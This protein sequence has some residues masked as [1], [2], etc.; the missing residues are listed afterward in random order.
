[1]AAP[2]LKITSSSPTYDG[3]SP[4]KLFVEIMQA[5]A[6]N[7]TY[8]DKVQASFFVGSE[9]IILEGN[10]TPPSKVL[11]QWE[12]NIFEVY[13]IPAGDQEIWIKTFSKEEGGWTLRDMKMV[14]FQS[15]QVILPGDTVPGQ[16]LYPE[17]TLPALEFLANGGDYAASLALIEQ[18]RL[19]GIESMLTP[20]PSTTMP[21]APVKVAPGD[22]NWNLWALGLALGALILSGKKLKA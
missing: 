19:A 21:K 9:E 11:S 3:V 14:K 22:K 10:V 15:G 17:A 6:P 13:L 4:V 2:I 12:H 8:E 18:N 1:M 20:V 7:G 16:M 5:P